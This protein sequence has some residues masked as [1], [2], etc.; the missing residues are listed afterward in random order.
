[1]PFTLQFRGSFFHMADFLRRLD[2]F[3]HAGGRAVRVGGRLLTVDGVRLE[4][5]QSG[6]PVMS[7]TLAANAY[8]IPPGQDATGGASPTAPGTTTESAGGT[9]TPS[10]PATAAVTSTP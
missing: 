4:P 6:F 10:A 9:S 5:A 7:A 1:M 8:L 2:R 3:V